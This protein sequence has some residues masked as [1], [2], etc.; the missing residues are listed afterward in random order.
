VITDEA[1]EA[2]IL[3]VAFS[4]VALVSWQ[5][6]WAEGYR[7]AALDHPRPALR[8]NK[9]WTSDPPAQPQPL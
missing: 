6:G 1:L 3:C 5:L 8:P 2:V 9:G 7:A 4:A